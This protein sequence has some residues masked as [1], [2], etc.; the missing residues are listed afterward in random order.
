MG[1]ETKKTSSS[2]YYATRS[3]VQSKNPVAAPQKIDPAA[4]EPQ[5]L[6]ETSVGDLSV[7]AEVWCPIYKWGQR[8]NKVYITI[9]VPCLQKDAATVRVKPQ[10]VHFRAERVAIF[11]GGKTQQRVYE[12][13][14]QL[15]G[16]VDA[17]QP[18]IF[19]RHDHVRVELLKTSAKPWR[20][21]QA[22]GV[23]KNP[24]EVA[25]PLR[26]P[27][28]PRPPPPHPSLQHGR[29]TRRSGRTLTTSATTPTT[30][31]T[32]RSADPS[33]RPCATACRS[34]RPH[35][36]SGWCDSSAR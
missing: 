18:E 5:R 13:S 1:P 34:A 12:L 16:E 6:S 7:D 10:A 11:A 31:R 29:A 26:P 17:D 24:N 35:A 4:K 14:L 36:R 25:P 28:R 33:P 30:R 2:Y 22:Q 15:F 19:L 32:R 27:L 9:F 3:E 23:P 20:S 21:L 8:K